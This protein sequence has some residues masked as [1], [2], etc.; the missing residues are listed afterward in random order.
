MLGPGSTFSLDGDEHRQR[1]KLLVPPFH[2]KRM[3][4]YEAI[5]EE[6]VMRET[7]TWPGGPGVRNAAADD[8]H[9]P[10]R[11]PAYGVRG[12]G[13]RVRRTAATASTDGAAWLPDGGDAAGLS[14]ATSA[15]GARGDGY[16]GTAGATTRSSSRSSPKREPIR[17]SRSAPTC[18]PSCCRHATRTARRSPTATSPTNC[19]RCSP[20][21]TRRPRRRWHGRS[22]G[23]AGIRGCCPG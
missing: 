8:A 1:R 10:Q 3:P 9:H 6:E 12:P 7:D 15:R 21:A 23:Y 4:G 2:G 16:S 11:H 19:S 5:V 20:R 18:S 13:Q 22:N 14:G 17:R